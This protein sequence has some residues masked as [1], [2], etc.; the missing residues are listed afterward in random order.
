M[1]SRNIEKEREI[2]RREIISENEIR[3]VERKE[4]KTKVFLAED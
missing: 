4:R 1:E 2:E 3:G